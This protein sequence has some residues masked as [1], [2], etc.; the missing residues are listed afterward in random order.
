MTD[1]I[2]ALGGTLELTSSPGAGTRLSGSLPAE[3]VATPN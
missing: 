3:L 2:D 1:R